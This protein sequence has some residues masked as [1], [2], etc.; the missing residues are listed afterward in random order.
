MANTFFYKIDGDTLYYSDINEDGTWTE[1]TITNKTRVPSNVLRAQPFH[2]NVLIELTGS[3][4]GLF[5][6]GN[7]TYIDFSGFTFISGS[8]T[9]TFE[10]DYKLEHLIFGNTLGEWNS[11][12]P[13]FERVGRD[14]QK[15]T[16]EFKP[17][18]IRPSGEF[19][20]HRS[21]CHHIEVKGT[22][23]GY[24]RISNDS[25]VEIIDMREFSCSW[26]RVSGLSKL[27][28]YYLPTFTGNS[29]ADPRLFWDMGNN[30]DKGTLKLHGTI[31]T[32]DLH[33]LFGGDTGWG[34][35]NRYEILDINDLHFTQPATSVS[36]L[37]NAFNNLRKVDLSNITCA[38]GCDIGGMVR[39]CPSLSELTLPQFL[40][41]KT[42]TYMII[43]SGSNNYPELK[44][45]GDISNMHDISGLFAATNA[46]VNNH[47][48]KIL[49]LSNLKF[50]YF[51]NLSEAFSENASVTTIK[52]IKDF[53]S[54]K[55]TNTNGTFNGLNK[56]VGGQGSTPSTYGSS[57]QY[58]RI[59]GGSEAPGYF[60]MG[61]PEYNC[62]VD[63][64]PAGAATIE[65]RQERDEFTFSI[66]SN[67]GYTFNYFYYKTPG[68]E[69]GEKVKNINQCRIPITDG[70]T[71]I[72]YFRY[73]K[74]GENPYDPNKPGGGT[75]PIDDLPSD[76]TPIETGIEKIEDMLGSFSTYGGNRGVYKIYIP[77][78]EQ[79]QVW[80]TQL[81]SENVF[82]AIQNIV[83]NVNVIQD[84]IM[85]YH[86]L[87]VAIPKDGTQAPTFNMAGDVLNALF[88]TVN[89]D[90]T[91]KKTV[92]FSLGSIKIDRVW[93]NHLDYSPYTSIDLYLPFIGSR[94][95]DNDDVMGKT[96]QIDYQI[97]LLTGNCTAYIKVNGQVHYQFT[98]NCLYKIP[99][100]SGD[101][102]VFKESATNALNSWFST[103]GKSFE[104]FMTNKDMMGSLKLASGVLKDASSTKPMPGP[105]SSSV[106]GN[107]AFNNLNYA[108]ITITRRVPDIPT[109][110][111]HNYGF[112]CNKTV[113]LE[114]LTGYTE[115]ES[116]HLDG[117]PYTDE[118]LKELEGIM[119]GGF[120]I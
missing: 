94:K 120:I 4:D 107:P 95:L 87:P 37:I 14:S 52:V 70:G 47:N 109:S 31:D 75:V 85:G 99:L 43:Y 66:V 38:N 71:Y 104:E 55:T 80:M 50:S 54:D 86:I 12:W 78:A 116:I 39:G 74:T 119:K 16:I 68:G 72:A 112:P 108:Y 30:T 60:T 92:N 63:V 3:E 6:N 57:G 101:G 41:E 10:N 79:F 22:M 1:D 103:E 27:K 81:Y 36:L 102:D 34:D 45:K 53:I 42:G 62:I 21:Q 111:G 96:I 110:Y 93:F 29:N 8:Y 46:A 19:I 17:N 51:T 117:L 114:D 48:Y 33:S 115:V 49:D 118:E 64:I 89:F 97:E 15:L 84:M 77:T 98:G 13:G 67:P 56:L 76:N 7:Y 90:Y 35:T 105:H 32:P 20:I 44:I 59:D 91:N 24:F 11:D 65:W 58:A 40:G 26:A 18:S 83:K 25:A 100:A 61:T 73:Q 113:K 2:E 23:Q 88:N 82:Q 9:R 5:S 69:Y 106:Q 28:E